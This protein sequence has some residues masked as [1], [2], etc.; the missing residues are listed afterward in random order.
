[1]TFAL[2]AVLALAAADAPPVIELRTYDAMPPASLDKVKKAL[3][4]AGLTTLREA[5]AT[6][7]RDTSVVYAAKGAEAVAKQVAASVPGG[8]TVEP[9]TW[10]SDAAVIVALGAISTDDPLPPPRLRED[11]YYVAADNESKS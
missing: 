2:L 8:A 5:K 10:K 11:G 7:V 9:L 3:T 6:A 1:P 4:A